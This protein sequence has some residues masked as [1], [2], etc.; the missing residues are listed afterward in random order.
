MVQ[1]EIIVSLAD[2]GRTFGKCRELGPPETRDSA[3]SIRQMLLLGISARQPPIAM[4]KCRLHALFWASKHLPA[5]SPSWNCSSRGY[6]RH[7][8]SIRHRG[9]ATAAAPEGAGKPYYVT[10]P[11]FYVNAGG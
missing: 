3:K 1:E 5:R 10:T 9:F 11:I 8:S 7:V 4:A 2:S 6:T